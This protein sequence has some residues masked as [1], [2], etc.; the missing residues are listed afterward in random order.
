MVR[1]AEL[2]DIEPVLLLIKEFHKESIDKFNILCDE[3][4]ARQAMTK[5][6]D[7]SFVLELDNKIV[8]VFGGMLTN[9]PLNDST[10]YAEWIW[11]VLPKYRLHGVSL[12]HKVRIL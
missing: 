5:F 8:G 4:I 2:K 12:Y 11:Y 10:V 1:K 3:N 6:V 9:Y 7:T